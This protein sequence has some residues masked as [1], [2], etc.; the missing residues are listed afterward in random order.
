MYKIDNSYLTIK[1][2]YKIINEQ[3]PIGLSKDAT[4]KILDCRLS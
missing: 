2:L 4:L 1:K 3:E